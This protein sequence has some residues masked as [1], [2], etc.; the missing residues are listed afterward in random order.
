MNWAIKHWGRGSRCFPRV[1][2]SD[3]P[4]LSRGEKIG[5]RAAFDAGNFSL[6]LAGPGEVL[7]G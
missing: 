2:K 7:A 1:F 4:G 6:M 5:V 3:E